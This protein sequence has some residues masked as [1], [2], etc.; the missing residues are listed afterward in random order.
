MNHKHFPFQF[1]SH[2]I[3]HLRDLQNLLNE[4]FIQVLNV[5]LGPGVVVSCAAL[6]MYERFGATILEFSFENQIKLGQP[7]WVHQSLHLY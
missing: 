5:K 4:L 6:I 2:G 7:E 3:I 1:I